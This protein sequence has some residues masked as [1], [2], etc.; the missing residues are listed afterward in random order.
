[1]IRNITTLHGFDVRESENII[2]SLLFKPELKEGLLLFRN[3]LTSLRMNSI[4]K[5]G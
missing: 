3:L 4:L 2:R 1:M 5:A